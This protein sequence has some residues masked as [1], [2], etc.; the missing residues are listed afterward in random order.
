[1]EG[2]PSAINQTAVKEAL[3]RIDG[4]KDVHDLHIWTITSGLDSM[5]CHMLV[6]DGWDC[7]QILQQAIELMEKEFKIHHSTIQVENSATSHMEMKV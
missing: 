4:V 2:T 7:Q 1:M 6:K 5:S 3:E